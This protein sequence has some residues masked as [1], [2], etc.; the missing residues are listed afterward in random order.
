[1]GV[2]PMAVPALGTDDLTADRKS[3]VITHE[4]QPKYPLI[5][6]A[7]LDVRVM[8]PDTVDNMSLAEA[9]ADDPEASA[10]SSMVDHI[11][12]KLIFQNMLMMQVAVRLA[13]P[14]NPERPNVPDKPP[15]VRSISI[16]WPT[17]TSLR[18]TE[19]EVYAAVRDGET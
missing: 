16:D 6:P 14:L 11:R 13:L 5:L 1:Y 12:Q 15:I 8:D 4:Y 9:L 18:T 19:L 7:Q 10:Y 17:I 3:C 2:L